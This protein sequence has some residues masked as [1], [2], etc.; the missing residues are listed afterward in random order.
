MAYKNESELVILDR[1]GKAN[2][3]A[4][5][6]LYETYD[7][8]R[9]LTVSGPSL[10]GSGLGGLGSFFFKIAQ[11]VTDSSFL[12]IL[13]SQAINIP[14]T[15]YFG[16]TQPGTGIVPGGSS[17]F[18][19]GPMSQVSGF[20]QAG[21][22]AGID[23]LSIL[24]SVGMGGFPAGHAASLGGG[25]GDPG[26]SWQQASIGGMPVGRA[27]SSTALGAGGTA[28]SAGS[29]L[30]AAAGFGRNFIMPAAG[31]VSGIGGLLTT[32]APLM[33]QAGLAGLAS[34]TILNGI[35]GSILAGYQHV[36]NRVLVNADTILSSKVKNLETVVKMLEAQE[37]IVKK[38]LKESVEG[39]KKALQDL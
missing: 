39:D 19:L 16:P 6:E 28:V 38:L 15:S 17:S 36:S 1:L 23:A 12:P 10:G 20:P 21:S 37:E 2:D 24:G 22:A 35:A 5:A 30:V 31:V 25:Y 7:Q 8:L 32:L 3:S 13:G 34:G 14:G 27:A 11:M 29:G 18:G 33:G 9:D 26:F 4:K